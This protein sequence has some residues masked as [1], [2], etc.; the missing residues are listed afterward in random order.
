MQEW[1]PFLKCKLF[2]QAKIIMIQ[3]EIDFNNNL[4]VQTKC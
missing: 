3:I 2:I 4:G 1:K